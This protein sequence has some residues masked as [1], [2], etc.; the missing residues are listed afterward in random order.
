MTAPQAGAT[1]VLRTIGFLNGTVQS[2]A[3][4]LATVQVAGAPGERV[5]APKTIATPPAW[6]HRPAARRRVF[7]LSRNNL[8][9]GPVFYIN[10][11][12]YGHEGLH[13][14]FDVE[15]GTIE[16]WVVRNDPR[17]S[18]G[19]VSMETHP[20]HIHVNDFVVVGRGMWDPQTGTST[21]YQPLLP[22]GPKDNEVVAPNEYVVLKTKFE[23]FTGKTVFHCHILFHE[24]HGM[25]G[26]FRIVDR[27]TDPME[28]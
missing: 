22:F 2:P 25:M 16:E 1:L 27:L 11:M 19:G 17:L 13:D 28:M 10:G 8:P 24:D 3:Q 6:I 26:S 15:L 5:R 4:D 21:S 18:S 20:F 23:R 9:T 7:T 12:A 14:T